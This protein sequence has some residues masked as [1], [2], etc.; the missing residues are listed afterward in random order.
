MEKIENKDNLNIELIKDF[1]IYLE[2]K[3]KEPHKKC[4]HEK[5][6][7]YPDRFSVSDEQISWSTPYPEYNPSYFLH[8]DV[9]N[10]DITIC[11]NGWA[12]PEDITKINHKLK[13]LEGE[14][15]FNELNQP[16]NPKGR[17]GIKGRGLLGKWGPNLAVDA[18][19]TRINKDS[20]LLEVILIERSDNGEPAFPGGMVDGNELT[21]ESRERELEEECKL[22]MDLSNA[23]EFFSGYIDDFRNTDNAWIEGVAGHLHL[24]EKNSENV[25]PIGSDDAKTAKWVALDNK[26]IDRLTANINL[27]AL[28]MILKFYKKNTMPNSTKTQLEDIFKQYLK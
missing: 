20:G 8:D 22:K 2:N 3:F 13:S 23:D 25:I 14:I 1:E 15:K 11:E 28:K 21:K 24:D 26:I 9:I 6:V 17:T 4:R 12:D 10:N 27:V 5:H 19:I 16:I 18:V 7:S